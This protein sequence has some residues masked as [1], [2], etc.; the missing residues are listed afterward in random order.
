MK[1]LEPKSA[2]IGA[3]VMLG[4]VLF[5]PPL[6]EVFNAGATRMVGG[7]PL[8]FFYLFFA[9]AVLIGLM[10]FVIE[11]RPRVGGERTAV[12]K[13]RDPGKAD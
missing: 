4:M 3:L 8:L 12:P 2:Q 1:G 9:W 13:R 6:L 7:V 10:A 11:R 5:N